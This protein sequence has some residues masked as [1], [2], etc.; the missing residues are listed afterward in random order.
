MQGELSDLR[1]HSVNH[2]LLKKMRKSDTLQMLIRFSY[3]D[4]VKNNKKKIAE[5]RFH[6]LGNFQFL[7]IGQLLDIFCVILK[8][9]NAK[10]SICGQCLEKKDAVIIKP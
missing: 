1:I 2:S 3:T 9:R 8:K 6:S 10:N 4:N 7:K 5:K